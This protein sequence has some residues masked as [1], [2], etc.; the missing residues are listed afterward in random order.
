MSDPTLQKARPIAKEGNPMVDIYRILHNQHESP[1]ADKE[2][3]WLPVPRE[4]FSVIRH[5]YRLGQAALDVTWTPLLV[6]WL[7]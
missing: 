2:A 1:G 3:N 6:R 4:P 5:L 7:G